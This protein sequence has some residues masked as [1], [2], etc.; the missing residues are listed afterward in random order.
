M[1]MN[2]IDIKTDHTTSLP[3]VLGTENGYI[4]MNVKQITRMLKQINLV[5]PNRFPT[6]GF[7]ILT[8]CFP[9][10]VFFTGVGACFKV[11]MKLIPF[12]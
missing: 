9:R 7:Q 12:T 11:L 2:T 5:I 6:Y 3:R 4:R 10:N 1:C 8:S